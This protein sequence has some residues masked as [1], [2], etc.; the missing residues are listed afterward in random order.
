MLGQASML[1]FSS[2]LNP[3]ASC[4]Q[5]ANESFSVWHVPIVRLLAR[6]LGQASMLPFSSALN[7]L[8]SCI[9]WASKVLLFGKF[10]YYW[11][12]PSA[13][14]GLLPFSSALNPLPSCK[15]KAAQV[16]L[17]GTFP[18]LGCWPG[19]LAQARLL[20]FSIAFTTLLP[21]Y[22]SPLELV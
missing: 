2:A 8:P 21:A 16:L 22:E 7:P 11:P 10:S 9:W 18:L 6:M 5:K 4:R 20:P 19:D 12:G 1:P 14:V 15:Q 3:L 13:R 17:C